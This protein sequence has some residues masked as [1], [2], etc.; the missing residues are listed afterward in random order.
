M[1][2]SETIMPTMPLLIIYN[3]YVWEAL[4]VESAA[5]VVFGNDY[6]ELDEDDK[7]IRRVEYAR[8]EIMW[9]IQFMQKIKIVDSE[10]GAIKLD[11]SKDEADTEYD[12]LEELKGIPESILQ[13]DND[14]V[15]LLSLAVI[16]T[17]SILERADSFYLHPKEVIS[18]GVS[19]NEFIPILQTSK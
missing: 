15:F 18:N 4:D 16:G 8:Q 12:G 13:V 19:S 2:K 1:D 7:W 9:R 3:G 6:F 14:K 17:I 11:Y 5:C 10:F